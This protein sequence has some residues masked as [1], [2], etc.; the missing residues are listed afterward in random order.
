M[1]WRSVWRPVWRSVWRS[2]LVLGLV[3]ALAGAA[4]AGEAVLPA[5]EQPPLEME[6]VEFGPVHVACAEHRGS[7]AK[8]GKA[9]SAFFKRLEEQDIEYTGSLMGIFYDSPEEVPEGTEVAGPLGVK[10]IPGCLVARTHYKGSPD[11]IGPVY[12][13][14]VREAVARGLVPVGPA[15][16]AYAAMPASRSIQSTIMFVVRRLNRIHNIERMRED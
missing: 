13:R 14:L 9:I 11:K 4:Q 7:Y 12:E 10:I 3:G 5:G 15:I 6:I 1:V 2:V 16:E 8:V